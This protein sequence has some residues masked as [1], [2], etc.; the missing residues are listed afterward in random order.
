MG[1]QAEAADA[2]IGLED[3]ALGQAFEGAHTHADQAGGLGLAIGQPSRPILC[4]GCGIG[5]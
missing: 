3:P 2:D 4:R 5:H 1:P